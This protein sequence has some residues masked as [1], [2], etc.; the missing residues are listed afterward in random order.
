MTGLGPEVEH[1]HLA[2]NT[3]LNVKN[4]QVFDKDPHDV[5]SEDRKPNSQKNIH[6]REGVALEG[7][8]SGPA[9]L[10]NVG[11]DEDG[12]NRDCNEDLP[13]DRGF[14]DFLLVPPQ[15]CLNLHIADGGKRTGRRK[16]AGPGSVN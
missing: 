11:E 1:Q 10:E 4:L 13:Q 16:S 7:N 15:E 14:R 3:L 8:Q 6:G 12:K 9:K 2:K 5:E